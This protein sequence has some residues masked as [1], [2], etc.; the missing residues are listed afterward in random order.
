MNNSGCSRVQTSNIKVSSL[1]SFSTLDILRILWKASLTDHD[2]EGTVHA[3]TMI[4]YVCRQIKQ[5]INKYKSTPLELW[6]FLTPSQVLFITLF[7][8]LC[9]VNLFVHLWFV[10]IS[11]FISAGVCSLARPI[12]AG[13]RKLILI[14]HWR[15][16]YVL[17]VNKLRRRCAV[18]LSRNTDLICSL[19]LYFTCDIKFAKSF[20]YTHSTDTEEWEVFSLKKIKKTCRRKCCLSTLCRLSSCKCVI[21]GNYLSAQEEIEGQSTKTDKSSCCSFALRWHHTRPYAVN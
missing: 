16:S 6:N 8:Y 13:K 7:V 1:I 14:L 17:R 5:W 11:Y 19:C 21:T 10:C 20:E 12:T 9:I 15:R 18:K 2:P 4:C 3:P